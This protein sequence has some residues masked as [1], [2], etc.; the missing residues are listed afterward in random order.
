MEY[1]SDNAA[2][3]RGNADEPRG[4]LAARLAG[5][6][7]G[8]LHE[9]F[10]SASAVLEEERLSHAWSPDTPGQYCGRCGASVAG[11]AVTEAGCPFC[12]DQNVP[13]SGLTRLSAYVEPMRP[14]VLAMKFHKRWRL[15]E[16]L[17][18]EMARAVEDQVLKSH[19]EARWVV[20][21][22]PLHWRRR[23]ERGYNQAQL[24]AEALATQSALPRADL[25]KRTRHTLP[26]STLSTT[27]RQVNVRQAFAPR[28]TLLNRW[29]DLTGWSVLLVDDVKTTGST[30][31]QCTRVLQDMGAKRVHIAVASVADPRGQDFS[32]I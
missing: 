13:W 16:P 18:A 32:T 19:D 3:G 24:L 29:I 14:W 23:A 9:V 30:L 31:G 28:Q 5:A 2:G 26:Q 7:R 6:A 1:S 11:A 8:L 10:P 4:R 12:V 20:T 25:L 21:A 22:V 15:C 27:Q 17:A